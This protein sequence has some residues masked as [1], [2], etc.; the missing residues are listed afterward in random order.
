MQRRQ[1][2]QASAFASL[3]AVIPS[4][5]AAGQPSP[6]S[7]EM[8]TLS[9]YM[10]EAATRGLPQAAAEQAKFHILD[11]LAAIISGS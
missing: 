2:L 8:Q 7:P 3:G 6:I 10:S 5:R 4:A 11:S 9:T 1:L